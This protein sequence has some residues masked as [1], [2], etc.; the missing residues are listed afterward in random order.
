MSTSRD[1]R[2]RR[3]QAVEELAA[4]LAHPTD[5]AGLTAL[6]RRVLERADDSNV[7]DEAGARH[8][9]LHMDGAPSPAQE[10]AFTY[11]IHE[12]RTA[13]LANRRHAWLVGHPW[14]EGLDPL[15]AAAELAADLMCAL[16]A[17]GA[18][19]DAI[20]SQLEDALFYPAHT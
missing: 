14:G 2:L 11:L 19:A 12:E 6:L 13:Q 8:E 9:L 4:T 15:V 7:A 10:W 20:L 1:A 3:T 18:D 5:T 17:R 16:H